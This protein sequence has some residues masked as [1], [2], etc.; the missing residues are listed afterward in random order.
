MPGG[1]TIIVTFW[2]DTS[3]TFTDCSQIETLV[4]P[5][6]LRF[7]GTRNG[8]TAEWIIPFSAIKAWSQS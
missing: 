8:L 2:N 3:W 6:R 5:D 7:F 4:N 1:T